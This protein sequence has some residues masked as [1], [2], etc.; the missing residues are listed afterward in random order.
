[1]SLV[2]LSIVIS[3]LFPPLFQ[4]L[5]LQDYSGSVRLSQWSETIDMLQDH[6]LLGAGLSG[7][8]TV[9]KPYHQ[10]THLEIFQYPHNILLNIWVELGLLGLIAVGLLSWH[11][12]RA[13]PSIAIFALLQMI[14]HGLVDVPYFKNDLAFLTWIFLAIILTR[15]LLITA[16][17]KI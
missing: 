13:E 1:M 17:H 2:A 8:Q 7:Y 5:T 11:V 4:K 15:P 9:F 3:L 14:I 12:L 10:A 16:H 6:W